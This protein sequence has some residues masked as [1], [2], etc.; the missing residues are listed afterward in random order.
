M[1]DL[2]FAKPPEASPHLDQSHLQ[3]SQTT[4]S[5]KKVMNQLD[6][7]QSVVETPITN[8]FREILI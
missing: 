7:S 6:Q 2:K 5:T 1:T 4:S 8:N 3:S